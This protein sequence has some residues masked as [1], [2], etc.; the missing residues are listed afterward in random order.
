MTPIR[1]PTL[2]LSGS[3]PPEMFDQQRDRPGDRGA[4]DQ[5]PVNSCDSREFGP[6]RKLKLQFTEFSKKLACKQDIRIRMRQYETQEAVSSV[7]GLYLLCDPCCQKGRRHWEYGFSL[8]EEI[9][10][11]DVS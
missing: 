3:A 4:G 2:W 7:A 11:G 8:N 1:P 10:P 5:C 9:G 6:I